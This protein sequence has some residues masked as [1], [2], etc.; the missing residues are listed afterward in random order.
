MARKTHAFWVGVFFS[1]G[2]IIVFTVLIWLGASNWFKET[3]TYVSYFDTSVQG[4]NVDGAVKFRGVQVGRVT[5]I[6]VAPDGNLIEVVMEVDP[7]LKV[8]PTIGAKVEL[9]GITGIRYIELDIVGPEKLSQ[10]PKHSFKA[11][12]QEIPS[13]PAGFE[14]IELALRNAL[15]KLGAINGDAITFQT[16]QFLEA[17]TKLAN[18]ADSVISSPRLT[19]WLVSLDRTLTR[20]DSML[21]ALD[22]VSYN[23]DI[24]GTL[25][26]LRQGAKDFGQFFATA[27]KQIEQLNLASNIDTTFDNINGFI[28]NSNEVLGQLQYQSS[29]VMSNISTTIQALNEAVAHLNALMLTMD[30]Y[31]ANFLYTAPPPKEK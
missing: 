7:V 21:S 20:I 14:E 28:S 19:Y 30:T 22:M 26:D 11:K 3:K 29:E 23:T 31:P 1:A 12:Y 17:G 6:R 13:Y 18:S 15:N 10:S 9:T 2:V 16:T 8:G 24:K 5:A 4:L 25:K 27:N